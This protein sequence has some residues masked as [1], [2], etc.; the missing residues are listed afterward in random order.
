VTATKAA[1]APYA[2]G[3]SAATTVTISSAPHAVKLAGT[4]RR[5]EK[6]NVTVSGYNFYGRPKALSNVS[7]FSA[8]VTR[9]SGTSLSITITVKTSATKPG[10]KVLTLVFGNGT[11]TSVRYSLH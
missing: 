1:V 11:R 9:D 7:G 10:V 8:L 6:A 3:L 5:S 4:V 2:N